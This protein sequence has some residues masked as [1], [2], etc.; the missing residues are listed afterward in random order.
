MSAQNLRIVSWNCNGA[1]RNKLEVIDALRADV[2]IVQECEDPSRSTDAAYRIW[3]S[4]HLW[5]GSNKNKGLGVF[6]REGLSLASELLDLEP[7]QLFLPVRIDGYWPLLATWTM[8]AN[9]PTFGYIGQLWKFLQ[10]HRIFL[11]HPAAMVVGDLN[12]NATWDSWDRWWN[13][14][15]VVRDLA[16]LG[17]ESLYHSHFG[18]SQGNESRPTF[19]MHRNTSKPYHIDHG[20]AARDWD[21]VDTVCGRCGSTVE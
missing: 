13:H 6:A 15:D 16:E 7:L 3:A 9:S 17:L 12:S 4:N 1:L 2:L 18:E 8:R 10:S 11:D 14:S 19:F 21:R 20:F 5:V